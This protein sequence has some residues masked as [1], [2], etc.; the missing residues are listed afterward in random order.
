MSRLPTG[1]LQRS[2]WE[3]KHK[4]VLHTCK[5]GCGSMDQARL[6]CCR[7]CCSCCSCCSKCCC[8][9]WGSCMAVPP[10]TEEP[11]WLPCLLLP[12]DGSSSSTNG[13]LSSGDAA[14][15]LL[16]LAPEMGCADV[17]LHNMLGHSILWD[18]LQEAL[19]LSLVNAWAAYV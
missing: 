19:A 12:L 6:G 10:C 3:L 15:M 9:C 11:A 16:G 2:D 5:P 8:R 14:G 7:L 1:H 17:S 4:E 13:R 18:V